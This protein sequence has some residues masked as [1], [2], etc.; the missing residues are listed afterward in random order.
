MLTEPEDTDWARIFVGLDPDGYEVSFEQ[1]H[2][3]YRGTRG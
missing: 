3:E 2:E 1:F